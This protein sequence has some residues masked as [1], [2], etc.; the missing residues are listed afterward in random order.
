MVPTV[1][2][3]LPPPRLPL[4]VPDWAAGEDSSE[5]QVHVLPHQYSKT[6]YQTL[7]SAVSTRHC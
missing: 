2:R 5:V 6:R 1:P 7:I 4:P 3:W